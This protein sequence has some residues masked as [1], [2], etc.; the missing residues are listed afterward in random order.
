MTE[1]EFFSQDWAAAVRAATGRPVSRVPI[2]PQDLISPAASSVSGGPRDSGGSAERVP[3]C[4]VQ[5][6]RDDGG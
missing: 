6:L 4:V 3:A 1:P 2:R 5:G